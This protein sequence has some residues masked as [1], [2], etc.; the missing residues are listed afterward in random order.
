MA[1]WHFWLGTIGILLY[2]VPI[3]AAGITQGL[4][5]RA[6]D[7]LGRMQYPNFVETVQSIV[8]FWWARVFG[9][10]LYVAG[11][12]MLAINA[13]MTWLSRP[14]KYDVQVF[15]AP[16]LMQGYRDAP[17]PKSKLEG[18]PVIEAAVAI[19]RFSKMDWHRRWERLPLLFTVL[20]TVA[21][22]VASLFELIPT[23]LIR[24]N[25]PTIASVKPYT[26]LELA[27]RDIYVSE[28][29]YNCHSQMIRPMIAETQRYG[30]YSKAGE[31]IYDRP[32]Q[33]GSRRIGPD[34]AREGGRQS[35]FWHWDHL[36]SPEKRSPGSVMPSY[37]HLL[38]G[39]LNFGEIQ[40]RV[41]AVHFL[42]AP[43]EQE[44]TDAEAMAH[45][46]AEAV[47]A[48]IVAQGGTVSFE[49]KLIKDATAIALIAYLQRVGKDL[50]RVDT[51]PAVVPPT[52]EANAT[53]A[54]PTPAAVP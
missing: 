48:E 41:H 52:T 9:G 36:N 18:L 17:I 2:I 22:I 34:L 12:S 29:C 25:V 38:V 4:M 6:M 30:E 21:V 8:P 35:S 11:V 7:D 27:G 1:E 33:W 42:G 39:R 20:T 28:G 44:L 51:P 50:Y 13:T 15:T 23:F 5:W 47:A 37:R 54:V 53:A 31:F 45:K 32:F 24:A 43:Y 49:G 10:L 16:R 40:K 3:Y 14:S 26:P 46:Q 19:D